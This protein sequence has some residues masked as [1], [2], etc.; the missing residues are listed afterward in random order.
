MSNS[1]PKIE[2]VSRNVDGYTFFAGVLLTNKF[3]VGDL[4]GMEMCGKAESGR[5]ELTISK[6]QF[7][8]K[9][10][11]GETF[12][13]CG[14]SE[15][16]TKNIWKG[17]KSGNPAE[18]GGII[19]GRNNMLF[20]FEE[21]ENT[22]RVAVFSVIQNQGNPFFS[23]DH[24]VF[25]SVD[26]I[27]TPDCFIFTIEKDTSDKT[28]ELAKQLRGSAAISFYRLPFFT[29]PCGTAYRLSSDCSKEVNSAY[30]QQYKELIEIG[31]ITIETKCRLEKLYIS[32]KQDH[33]YLNYVK[34][35]S[36]RTNL[37]FDRFKRLLTEEE[38]KIVLD[39]GAA[40][41]KEEMNL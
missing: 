10:S 23:D 13:D 33:D 26:C 29:L 25:R 35:L 2:L 7:E 14:L 30:E 24:T 21:Q 39:E 27:E 3:S 18:F 20:D 22:S 5:M 37:P 9:S 8:I 28:L 11:Y 1:I 34:G 38:H 31:N 36:K 41:F 6:H 16:A 12:T 19:A 40:F 32:T 4:A 17:Y 15:L